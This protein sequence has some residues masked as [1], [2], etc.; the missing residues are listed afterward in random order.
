VA[1]A[2][3]IAAAGELGWVYPHCLAYFNCLAGGPARGYLYLADSNLDW[4]QD[5]KGLKQWM[6][7]KGVNHINLCYFG[8]ADPDY[9]HI[10]YTYLYDPPFAPGLAKPPQLPGYVAISASYLVDNPRFLYR[11]PAAVV[12]YSIHIYWV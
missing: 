3:V 5:L 11:P 10:H 9:Y 7:E 12:G 1:A 6:D 8:T 4:G 2:V